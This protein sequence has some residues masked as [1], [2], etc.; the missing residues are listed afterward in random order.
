MSEKDEL[1]LRDLFDS[2]T[3]VGSVTANVGSVVNCVVSEILANDGR[4]K[5]KLPDGSFGTLSIFER[6]PKDLAIGQTLRIYVAEK[7]SNGETKLL[8]NKAQ[9]IEGWSRIISA[10]EAGL[11]LPGRTI[12]NVF[13]GWEV[14]L[15]GIRGFWP[16]LADPR[17]ATEAA[18]AG[19][20]LDFNIVSF[21]R[22]EGTLLVVTTQQQ[23]LMQSTK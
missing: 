6:L 19:Q 5:F 21:D 7:G 2:E 16:D 3:S 12:R 11:A 17:L 14:E 23:Q 15:L 22:E 8:W 20:K 10:S 1:D 18:V 9:E 13:A 4:V